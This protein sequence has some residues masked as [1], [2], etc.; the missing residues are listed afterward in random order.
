MV[1]D[2]LKDDKTSGEESF[3]DLFEAYNEDVDE[4]VQ[5]GDKVR[6]EI[7]SIGKDTVFVD[8]GTK[9][10]GIVEKE[11]LLDENQEMPFK[12]GDQLELYVVSNNGTGKK[13]GLP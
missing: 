10:D 7:I 5:V 9:I 11:E 4:D 2:E 3:A 8:T 12:E 6:G 1:S 13:A